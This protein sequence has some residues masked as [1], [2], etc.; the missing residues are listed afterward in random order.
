MS[1]PLDTVPTLAVHH[2]SK[3]FQTSAEMV[4]VLIDLSLAVGDGEFVS[5]IGPSGCGKS[6]L[7]NVISGLE[8]PDA[9]SVTL[10]GMNITGTIGRIGYMPQRDSLMPWRTVLDNTILGLEMLGVKRSQAREEARQWFPRF[11][12]E[13]FESEYPASLSGGMRQRAAL[14]RTFLARR[15]VLLLDE[16][17]GALDALTRADMQDW[18]LSVWADFRKT[19]LLV[20]HDIDEAIYLAD[21]VYVLSPRPGRVAAVIE[22]PLP[23]PRRYEQVV[24]AP[25]FIEVKRRVL[26]ALHHP[27]GLEVR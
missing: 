22:S 3:S 26:E 14:L 11:G 7:F 2:V 9:G 5:I 12:L 18:L 6:T 17:F 19:V 27:A 21:R 15:D 24:T 16:P 23:R 1:G 10:D 25:D 20:T 13:G 8:T 4:P